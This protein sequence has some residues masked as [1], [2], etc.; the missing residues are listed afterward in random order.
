VTSILLV[1]GL[2]ILVTRIRWRR[3]SMEMAA[4]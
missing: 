3:W 4:R 1:S 2:R